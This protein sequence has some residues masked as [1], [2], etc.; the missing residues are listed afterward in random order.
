MAPSGQRR[1]S[2]SPGTT[3]SSPTCRSPSTPAP[4]IPPGCRQHLTWRRTSCGTPMLPAEMFQTT[5]RRHPSH[6]G[7]A[8][9]PDPARAAGFVPRPRPGSSRARDP[10]TP[11]FGSVAS[12]AARDT[13]TPRTRTIADE[14]F[15]QAS[16][17]LRSRACTLPLG[18]ND[19]V[20]FG[21]D[22]T[23]AGARDGKGYRS[24]ARGCHGPGWHA[25]WRGDAPDLSRPR[26]G[27]HL[28]IGATD[29]APLR[30]GPAR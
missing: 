28:G 4:P 11:H 8:P 19:R 6:E 29:G 10:G 30:R 1:R 3:P 18:T 17:H 14:A 21:I 25:Q 2:A 24:S 22:R 13:S 5:R 7:P 20:W 15:V 23:G 26:P 27:G 9:G 16:M 12:T